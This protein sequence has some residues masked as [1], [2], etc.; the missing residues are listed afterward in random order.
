MGPD[1]L[2]LSESEVGDGGRRNGRERYGI[3]H[4]RVLFNRTLIR[5]K[6]WQQ[7]KDEEEGRKR[8]S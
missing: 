7:E 2:R 6:G 3:L 8:A 4:T 1:G 5:A